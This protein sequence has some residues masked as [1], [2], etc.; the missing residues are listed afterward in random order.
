MDLRGSSEDLRLFFL[1]LF[2]RNLQIMTYLQQMKKKY[3]TSFCT[4]TQL[5]MS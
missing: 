4:I 1:K 2:H 5:T 3:V